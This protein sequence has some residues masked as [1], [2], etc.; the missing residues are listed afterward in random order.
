MHAVVLA[1]MHVVVCAIVHAIVHTSVH[2]VVHA[3]VHVAVH[4]FVHAF[5]RAAMQSALPLCCPPLPCIDSCTHLFTINAF[6]HTFMSVS[7]QFE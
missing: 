2:A 5:V 6:T 4:A 1:D 3:F 7:S